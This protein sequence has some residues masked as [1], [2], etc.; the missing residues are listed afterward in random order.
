[1]TTKRPFGRSHSVQ[2]SCTG[3][4]SGT[5]CTFTPPSGNPTSTATLVFATSSSTPA[6]TYVVSVQA[7]DGTI[8]RTSGFT[9]T[10]GDPRVAYD[11]ET[12]TGSGLMTDLSGHGNDGTITGTTIV[13]GKVGLARHFNAGD[14]ITAPAISVPD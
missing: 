11:M 4:P 14:R 5:T 1:M 9:L 7:S 3:L 6:G 12:L 13:A 8:T 2:Y 10:V